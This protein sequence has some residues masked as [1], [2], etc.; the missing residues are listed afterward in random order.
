L[1]KDKLAQVLANF[2]LHIFSQEP[3]GP[4]PTDDSFESLTVEHLSRYL[5]HPFYYYA[6]DSQRFEYVSETISIKTTISSQ[7]NDIES[8]FLKQ[9]KMEF[10]DPTDPIDMEM[11]S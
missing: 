10:D 3:P 5:S 8:P 4:P 7:E 9:A 6:G 11:L 2:R 1:K